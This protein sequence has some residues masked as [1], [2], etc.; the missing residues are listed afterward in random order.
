MAI[1]VYCGLDRKLTAEHV[2]SDSI[3][4]LFEPQADT[5]FDEKRERVYKGDPTVRDLCEKCNSGLSNADTTARDF[6]RRYCLQEIPIGTQLESDFAQLGRWALKTA[7]N[8]E[9]S[10][11]PKGKPWWKEHLASLKGE[12]PISQDIAIF[13]GAW[14]ALSPLA[15]FHIIK[16][17]QANEAAIAGSRLGDWETLRATLINRAWCLKVGFG[18][19]SVLVFNSGVEQGPREQLI[20]EMRGYGWL[21][22]GRDRDVTK[23]PF[24]VI[25]SVTPFV[26]SDPD[27]LMAYKELTQ[28]NESRGEE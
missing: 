22:L 10:A 15:P 1:C 19:F 24:N 25:T 9:R 18:V 11:G 28:K 27:N 23:I 17:L 3:L 14:R 5:T 7:A 13:F 21:Q 2:W 12:L 20:S 8:M 6:V 4:R 26:L 16:E